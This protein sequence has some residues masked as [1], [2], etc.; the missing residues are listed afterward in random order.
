MMYVLAMGGNVAILIIVKVEESLHEPMYIFLCMLAIVDLVLCNTVLPKMLSMLWFMQNKIS[1]E[2]CFTQMFLVHSFTV[3]ESSVL[4]AM[5]F[6]RYTAICNPLRYTTIFTKTFMLKIGLFCFIR[7]IILIAPEPWLASR[8]PYCASKVVPIS[9]CDHMSVVKLAC[10]DTTI[11]NAYGLA[12][13]ILII[14]VDS[15]LIVL[16]YIKILHAVMNLGSGEERKKALNT[17]GS[18][19]CVVLFTYITALFSLITHRISKLAGSDAL[20]TFSCLYVALPGMMNPIIYGI[21]TKEIRKH[22]LKHL[23]KDS[24]G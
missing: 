2:G 21:R 20:V 18:H 19:L 13:L 8:L 12:A 3:A 4:L 9:Y 16:S 14:F 15:A 11:N 7:G 17:C 23:N 1:F 6:D 22:I 5:A 10:T 24:T